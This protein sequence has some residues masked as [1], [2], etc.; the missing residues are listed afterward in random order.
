MKNTMRDTDK[1]VKRGAGKALALSLS[2]LAITTTAYTVIPHAV[3]AQSYAFSSVSVEGNTRV[4]SDTILSY[5]GIARGEQ[6]SAAS[7]N[8]A[9]QRVVASG[10]F[11]T[12]EII[13]NGGRLV[14]KVTEFPIVSRVNIEGNRV[15]NQHPKQRLGETVP[16]LL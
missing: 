8:D 12:V 1:R 2:A 5:A 9:Y 4:G 13:P 6:I 3:V 7:L 16:P 14:I 10:L 11:E 15:L